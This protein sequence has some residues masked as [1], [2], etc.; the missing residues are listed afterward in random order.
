MILTGENGSTLRKAWPILRKVWP[1]AMLSTANPKWTVL[2]SNWGVYGERRATNCEEALRSIC[3]RD[4]IL[5]SY[6]LV[7]ALL[8]IW[9]ISGSWYVQRPEVRSPG[10]FICRLTLQSRGAKQK[11]SMSTNTICSVCWHAAAHERTGCAE[12]LLCRRSWSLSA[13]MWGYFK[14]TGAVWC[15]CY[16][17]NDRGFDSGEEQVIFLFS[18]A[19][20][21][22]PG[23]RPPPLHSFLFSG[24]WGLLSH[25]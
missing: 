23:H 9:H 18:K 25:K 11:N 3:V 24:Y 14:Q 8:H 12:A 5:S 20:R 15:Q 4:I 2:G 1:S 13:N 22:A 7:S 19:S 6:A 21:P 10:L 17:L 16:G